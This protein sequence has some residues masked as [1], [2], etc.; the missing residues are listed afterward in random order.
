M[1]CLG[2]VHG[3][4]QA[5]EEIGRWVRISQPQD[6]VGGMVGMVLDL[7]RGVEQEAGERMANMPKELL[8][9]W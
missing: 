6:E 2:G 7:K 5:S 3:A 1:E 4:G 8:R 9:V